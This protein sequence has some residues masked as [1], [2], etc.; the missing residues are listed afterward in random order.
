MFD[1]FDESHRHKRTRRRSEIV[2]REHD[3][4]K[5]RL[6]A[7]FA[8]ALQEL[9]N[10]RYVKLY[11]I[12]TSPAARASGL[13]HKAIMRNAMWAMEELGYVKDVNQ[14]SVDGR[15]SFEGGP[16][17]VYR[18][19]DAPPLDKRSVRFEVGV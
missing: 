10:P 14:N 7:T 5:A 6:K 19:K 8:R 2:Q 1:P 18:L 11:D 12:W 9:R 3:E 13:H 17:V 16:A 15:W 4:W